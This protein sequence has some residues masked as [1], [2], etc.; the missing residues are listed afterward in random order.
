MKIWFGTSKRRKHSLDINL[1]TASTWNTVYGLAVL[2]IPV[3]LLIPPDF[4]QSFGWCAL[5]D[6]RLLLWCTEG[7]ILEV[8][9]RKK[10][11]KIEGDSDRVTLIFEEEKPNATDKDR[12]LG[13]ATKQKRIAIKQLRGLPEIQGGKL[14]TI[15]TTGGES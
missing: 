3:T 7:E 11:Q 6:Q 1:R 12:R 10:V 5:T 14:L 15:D 9:D 13:R 2:S 4:G 8:A